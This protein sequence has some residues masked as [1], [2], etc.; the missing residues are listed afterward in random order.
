VKQ[1][2][3]VLEWQAEARIEAQA[4]AVLSALEA[5]FQSVPTDLAA[6]IQGTTEEVKLKAWLP[7]AVLT[8]SIEK[9]RTDAGL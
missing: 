2:E 8:P 6:K 3:Q 9:F 5:K 1:S 7:L 4:A